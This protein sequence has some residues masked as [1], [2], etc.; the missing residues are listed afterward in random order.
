MLMVLSCS[1]FF[2]VS[3][4]LKVITHLMFPKIIVKE[5]EDD[6]K[7]SKNKKYKK[8]KRKWGIRLLIVPF[9]F[10]IIY[11]VLALLFRSII[12]SCFLTLAISLY[13]YFRLLANEE[14]H[15]KTVIQQIKAEDH[16]LYGTRGTIRKPHSAR[17]SSVCCEVTQRDD[18]TP[19]LSPDEKEHDQE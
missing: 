4:L 16:S 1:Y 13:L 15:R 10:G 18:E 3:W 17:D 5:I 11:L 8:H 14:K 2:N 6:Y 7:I 19:H 9:I 12:V